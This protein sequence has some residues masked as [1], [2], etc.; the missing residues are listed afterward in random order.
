[1]IKTII[2]DIDNTLYDY[3]KNHVYG[4]KALADYCKNKF[5]ITE[6]KMLSFYDQAQNITNQRIGTDTAAIHSRMLRFQC[7]TELMSQ[8]LFPHVENMYHSYWDTLI[9]YSEPSPGAIALFSELKKRRIRIGIGTDMTATIQY[10]KLTKLG[11]APYIDF[12]VTS[13]EAGVEKPH[14]HFFEICVEKA[15]CLPA[16]CAFIGDHLKKDVQGAIDNGLFGIWYS[17]EKLPEKDVSVPTII[18]FSD[19]DYFFQLCELS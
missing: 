6:D 18:S 14:P 15:G 17:Q 1:M 9:S 8:P 3:D 16:E 13:Q 7:M 19:L 4:M 10:K 12:I 2:F 11:F 5:G